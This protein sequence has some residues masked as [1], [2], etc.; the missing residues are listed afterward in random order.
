MKRCKRL[1]RWLLYLSLWQGKAMKVRVHFASSMVRTSTQSRNGCLINTV[2]SRYTLLESK[3]RHERICQITWSM[4]SRASRARFLNI[5]LRHR[6]RDRLS[7]RSEWIS[8]LVFL[9]WNF[10]TSRHFL[11]TDWSRSSRGRAS[12]CHDPC[13]QLRYLGEEV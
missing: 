6:Q 8:S 5:E 11:D 10:D 1:Q 13:W 12:P 7:T 2:D 4:Q 3:R 9:L